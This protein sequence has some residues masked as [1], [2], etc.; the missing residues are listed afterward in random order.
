[1]LPAKSAG[2]FKCVSKSWLS[3]I[4][5]QAFIKTHL[6]ISSRRDDFQHH[7]LI[8][9]VFPCSADGPI[10]KL[11]PVSSLLY[12]ASSETPTGRVFEIDFPMESSKKSVRPVGSCNGLVCLRTCG[13]RELYLC[14]PCTKIYKK[15]PKTGMQI[16]RGNKSCFGLGYD[17]L[18]DDYKIV[19]L[20]HDGTNKITE[21]HDGTISILYIYAI[22][23]YSLKNNSWR[24]IK[25]LRVEVPDKFRKYY[26][27]YASGKLHWQVDGGKIACFD[28]ENE[29][30][31][32]MDPPGPG[33][34]G[35]T[36]E[37]D[38]QL[39]VLGDWLSLFYDD[40]TSGHAD[41]WVLKDSWIKVVYAPLVE[42]PCGRSYNES[43]LICLQWND[44][45]LFVLYNRK[46]NTYSIHPQQKRPPG[47]TILY[48]ES[49]V[50]PNIFMKDNEPASALKEI[51][52]QFHFLFPPSF[53][54]S[55]E[56]IMCVIMER[57]LKKYQICVDPAL[58][59]LKRMLSQS[60]P[61]LR[62]SIRL[63]I[64]ELNFFKMFCWGVG[65]S[66]ELLEADWMLRF[67][68]MA[69]KFRRTGQDLRMQFEDA[70][71]G[72]KISNWERMK[73]CLET[74]IKN[75]K[76][77][78]REICILHVHSK[79]SASS[80][81]L[82]GWLPYEYGRET[83]DFIRLI[84]M[85]LC[86]LVSNIH[87]I[88]PEL[89]PQ[90]VKQR[91]G[92]IQRKLELFAEFVSL[93]NLWRHR[94]MG[95]DKL[96]YHIQNW[97]S[98][99]SSL[100][101]LYWIDGTDLVS[102]TS[103]TVN[104]LSDLMKKIMS[105]NPGSTALFLDVFKATKY[106]KFR[107]KWCPTLLPSYVD[108]LLEHL[109]IQNV[110]YDI[111]LLREGLLFLLSFVMDSPTGGSKET[112]LILAEIYAIVTELQS[113]E[114]IPETNMLPNFLHMID[115][116]KAKVK[117]LYFVTPFSSQFN[118]PSSNALGFLDS[119]LETLHCILE[120]R[121]HLIPSI[122]NHVVGIH[123]GLA[124]LKS[125]LEHDLESK[126][127]D[128]KLK[129]LLMQI[130]NVIHYASYVTKLCPTMSFSVWFGITCLPDVVHHI[131][132]VRSEEDVESISNNLLRGQKDLTIISISGMPG[133]GKTTLARRIYDDPSIQDHFPRVA[134]CYVSKECELISL[135]AN[136]LLED[137]D[138]KDH[139][140]TDIHD[141]GNR[142][143]RSFKG[144]RY[145][146]VLDDIWDVDAWGLVQSFFPDD[147]N[148]S[149]ILFTSRNDNLASQCKQNSICHPLRLF[150]D[151]ESWEL[152]K[153]K[154]SYDG[155][156]PELLE[157]GKQ[158]AVYC[159]G[160]PLAVV[161]IAS[162]LNRTTK[163][164]DSWMEVKE[165]LKSHLKSEGCMHIVELS[166]K[167]LPNHLKPCFI[168]IGVAFQRGEGIYAG[169]LIN[170]WTV[171]G[172]VKGNE[173]SPSEHVGR[174][175]LDY[176]VS[177]NL[178][179][180]T[181]RGSTGKVK[182][183]TVHDLI[184][185]LCLQKATEHNLLQMVCY[186]TVLNHSYHPHA[187]KYNFQHHWLRIH[188]NHPEAFVDP[189][190]DSARMKL[191][192][193]SVHSL[194]WSFFAGLS[195][196]YKFWSSFL[197]NF[198][199]LTVL[200]MMDV[201]LRSS[202]FPQVILY[203]IHLRYLALRGAFS[204]VPPSITS[205]WRLEML[206]LFPV[207]C[208]VLLPASL[209]KMKSLSYVRIR[210]CYFRLDAYVQVVSSKVETSKIETLNGIILP[211]DDD[212]KAQEFLRSL[213]RLR[214]LYCSY[215][216]SFQPKWLS[217]FE[218]LQK[219]ESLTIDEVI[220]K[221]F[222]FPKQGW[223]NLELK[224][225]DTLK[226]LCLWHLGLPW[227]AMSTIGK[228][229]NLQ[230]LKLY[231]NACKGATW[232]LEEGNFSQLKCLS[233]YRVDVEQINDSDC[234][235]QPFPCLEKLYVY[236]CTRLEEVPPSFGAINTLKIIHLISSPQASDSVKAIVEQQKEW[237]NDVLSVVLDHGVKDYYYRV[238]ASTSFQDWYIVKRCLRSGVKIMV[239]A[240]G[241]S[242][243]WKPDFLFVRASKNYCLPWNHREM[244]GLRAIKDE[245]TQ[246]DDKCIEEVDA[247]VEKILKYSKVVKWNDV[248][249][250]IPPVST[251]ENDDAN[252]NIEI[253]TRISLET[254]VGENKDSFTIVNLD[255]DV[256]ITAIPAQ[257]KKKKRIM[258]AGDRAKSKK[259]RTDAPLKET[260]VCQHV[261]VKPRLILWSSP[262]D[263]ASFPS[264]VP[265]ILAK[266]PSKEDSIPDVPDDYMGIELE[267][268]DEATE[269][270]VADTSHS[271]VQRNVEDA[272]QNPSKDHPPGSDAHS[273]PTHRVHL[274]VLSEEQ[275]S[276]YPLYS[277][278]RGILRG[279]ADVHSIETVANLENDLLDAMRTHNVKVNQHLIN[280]IKEL[281]EGMKRREVQS[282]KDY[283]DS[284]T[285]EAEIHDE[286]VILK[287]EN[288]RLRE[289]QQITVSPWFLEKHQVLARV[290]HMIMTRIHRFIA[291]MDILKGKAREIELLTDYIAKLQNLLLDNNI[292]FEVFEHP[293]ETVDPRTRSSQ[294]EL[295]MRV[296]AQ[297][298]EIVDLKD[299]FNQ[300]VNLLS[301]HGFKGIIHPSPDNPIREVLV[302][303]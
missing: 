225:P 245:W 32:E 36:F 108:F 92:F 40:T 155:L 221:R 203:N 11:H 62:N 25:N 278:I 230:V 49:L 235:D 109:V 215:D 165:N 147:K 302:I 279:R 12:S 161:L 284:L 202:K 81:Q 247:D 130:S 106:H 241:G 143:R 219:L 13:N 146:I 232:D 137:N 112:K 70:S 298:Q 287:K 290:Q 65:F 289:R 134:W 64:V 110:D 120:G 283:G 15:L 129:D 135:L 243:E 139:G 222:L 276:E 79:V 189:A 261:K 193:S 37:F 30:Y 66:E 38:Y 271:G 259:A 48:V 201:N 115:G 223:R 35:S 179:V 116:V 233:L 125:F 255:E 227:K 10:N 113:V 282:L 52:F 224:F 5:N 266:D 159:Q 190:N 83:S 142:V 140:N 300:C 197:N 85:N 248:Q 237:E 58:Q 164:L 264:D 127:E 226:K 234:D 107:G 265:A 18:N 98:L 239:E 47:K 167:Y 170:L 123:E 280:E 166:Y 303:V 21:C 22:G 187:Q 275:S 162:V 174:E 117:E 61:H 43:Q 27:H 192:S 195:I 157:V 200:D 121:V 173:T 128:N 251:E 240:Y 95:T 295:L 171:E 26:L 132:L 19:E 6:A 68:F 297:D 45:V 131:E 293:E 53:P 124:S 294:E 73:S 178:I 177:Q 111:E 150:S 133:Q 122:K 14:N 60:P 1:M 183:C 9:S 102:L 181:Q 204:C 269:E 39:G 246:E 292:D 213:S 256:S 29:T 163:E 216:K 288:A 194:L 286:L 46:A 141:L 250:Y 214:K 34:K 253:S 158:I 23:V 105:Y 69:Q 152:M 262:A 59:I 263:I 257:K 84:Q 75:L 196:R 172:F 96:I 57:A 186:K 217:M 242:P 154:F 209:W 63:M 218:S 71:E 93:L 207:R 160:V 281:H 33:N 198:G 50:S 56:E 82:Q 182:R 208:H 249:Y 119:L 199:L 126:Y 180:V 168:Y 272:S 74:I 90:T 138:N 175:C 80:Y 254:P 2:R 148:G 54:D 244:E 149:R 114:C 145:F 72:E 205:L 67:T 268:A 238:V 252:A 156:P 97:A 78:A 104:M 228:L 291:A 169:K 44:K 51:R 16:R 151:D 184:Y 8:S 136:I 20:F 153:G 144:T 94:Y 299:K 28:L 188:D 210:N 277:M 231:Y 42:T 267:D 118:F 285:F 296:H 77:Q 211:C 101:C 103:T 31:G 4:S 220:P 41:I 229:P 24:E 17:K 274:M 212:D 3:L 206:L 7:G 87:L 91:I 273:W 260:A 176:L 301:L 99:I 88:A 270:D 191:P 258:K 86:T 100:A 236:F 89:E 76:L 185:D 55:V